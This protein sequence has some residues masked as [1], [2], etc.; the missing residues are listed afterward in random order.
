MKAWQFTSVGAPLRSVE[1]PD[2]VPGK[3][4]IVID[5]KA[6]GICHSDVGFMDGTITSLLAFTPIVLGHEIAGVISSV[7][8]GVT[9]FKVGQRVGIP[10]TVESPG[11]G[12]NGG[13][14]EKVCVMADQCVHIP[15]AVPFEQ[16]TPAMCAGKT[17]YQALVT[18]GRVEKGMNV[19]IIGFG[20]L[21]SLG[22]QIAKALG[23]NVYV[24]EVNRQ[25]WESAR[26]LGAEG[27]SDDIRDFESKQLDVIVDFA[28]YSVTTASAIDAVR[29]KGRVIQIGL[30]EEMATISIQKVTMKEI[31]YVGAAN[32][33]TCEGAD[34]LKLMADGSVKSHVIPVAFE[35]IPES[36]EKLAKGGVQGRFVA[37][38]DRE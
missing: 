18:A 21:G 14:A 26:K 32:A 5:I 2:P 38:I 19:G 23:A 15:D 29:P 6:A 9:D 8:Q 20:G 22:V 25:A 27:V 24:A 1:L 17:A 10:A 28:G 31:T 30:A 3:G 33:G 12:R 11:T 37:I 4:E 34:V 16:A 35:D 7:G 13:F 36:L